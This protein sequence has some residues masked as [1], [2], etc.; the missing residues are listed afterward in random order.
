MKGCFALLLL[1]PTILVAQTG[2][3]TGVIVARATGEP[4]PY[5]I[6]TL[7]GRSRSMFAN[8]SGR[9]AFRE[10]QPGQYV[11]RVKRLGF[12]PVDVVVAVLPGV[13]D[14]VRIALNRVTV[15]L[16]RITVSAYPACTAPGPPLASDT[17]LAAIYAQLVLNADQ[18]RFMS[19]QYPFEYYLQVLKARTL[20]SGAQFSDDA[21]TKRY[22]S[23]TRPTYRAGDVL[24]R[25]DGSWVLQIPELQ[26]VASS[27][28]VNSHCWHYAGTDTIDG[29]QHFRVDVVAAENLRGV[30]VDGSFYVN[31]ESFQI[32][33]SIVHL[34]RRAA[35]V[36][37]VMYMETTTHFQE[38]FPSVPIIANVLVVQTIDP[39]ARA[40][41]TESREI[42]SAHS[43]RFLSR[44]PGDSLTP[45][46]P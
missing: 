22:T 26:D 8:D 36:P 30:D 2:A 9:F 12:T 44:T 32:R 5:G 25:V 39:K 27:Q 28:F 16:D 35:E 17:T 43:Y 34:S 13:V 38:I 40:E 20:K 46:K 31:A 42:Q 37:A 4:L 33:R 29:K 14:T 10:L 7:E 45:G 11:I 6:V 23:K 1:V 15:R 24:R 19:E 18:L 3:V 21:Y 41:Y